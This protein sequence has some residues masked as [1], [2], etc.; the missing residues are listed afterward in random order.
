MESFLIVCTLVAIALLLRG[1][2][3]VTKRGEDGGGNWL[4]AYRA[5]KQVKTTQKGKA[6]K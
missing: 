1:Y 2:R 4:F 3:S 5:E 6:G